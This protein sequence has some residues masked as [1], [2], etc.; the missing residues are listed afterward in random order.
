MLWANSGQGKNSVPPF[1]DLQ[2]GGTSA[3][4]PQIA[5]A[6]AMWIAKHR[7]ELDQK[8]Y[9]GTWR[10]VEAVRKALFDSTATDS[11]GYFDYTGRGSLRAA[12]ALTHAPA[13]EN[14]LTMSPEA[15]TPFLPIIRTLF[16]WL[17]DKS[18]NAERSMDDAKSE[19]FALEIAQ[20]VVTEPQLADFSEIDFQNADALSELS[21]EDLAA[22]KKGIRESVNASEVLKIALK[23]SE[24]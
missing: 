12:D 9:S 6:A 22:L 17:G 23:V 14:L 3:A 13:D 2:G 21:N 8:G 18:G 4:T 20:L 1:Y 15:D 10:Q 5:A 16:G 7:A 24:K 11:H 19:M